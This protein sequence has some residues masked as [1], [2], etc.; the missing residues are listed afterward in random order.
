MTKRIGGLRKSRGKFKRTAQMKGKLSL[1]NYLANYSNGDNVL[2]KIDSISREGIFHPRFVGKR[3]VVVGK[4]GSSY[5]VKINDF[6][7]EKIIIV[8]PVH[9]RKC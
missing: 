4:R 2:L 1:R 3:G 5:E 6:S 8:H 9:L 7:K